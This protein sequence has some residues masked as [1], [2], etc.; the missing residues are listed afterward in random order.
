MLPTFGR[1]RAKAYYDHEH[2]GRRDGVE[3]VGACRVVV[4]VVGFGVLWR[5]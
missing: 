1:L 2:Y 3:V 5:R 4:L